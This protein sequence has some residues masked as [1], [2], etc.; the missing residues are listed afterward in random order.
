MQVEVHFSQEDK[1][2]VVLRIRWDLAA[3]VTSLDQADSTW[4]I[5]V[6][7]F[8]FPCSLHTSELIICKVLILPAPVG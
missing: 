7:L 3:K 5:S 8:S 6:H 4:P 1:S 2:C